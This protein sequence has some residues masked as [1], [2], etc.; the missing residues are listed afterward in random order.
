LHDLETELASSELENMKSLVSY[1][2][3]YFH[4]SDV[5]VVLPDSKLCP[6]NPCS[7]PRETYVDQRR[8]DSVLT[9]KKGR[10]NRN[11]KTRRTKTAMANL[12]SWLEITETLVERSPAVAG[13]SVSTPVAADRTNEYKSLKAQFLDAID[14]QDSKGLPTVVN[15]NQLVLQRLQDVRE[16]V[17]EE[18]IS[19][20][21]PTNAG[22]SRVERAIEDLGK[23]RNRGILNLLEGSGKM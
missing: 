10:P 2:L 11:D 8:I 7:L 5:F 6:Q 14:S 23:G 12:E 17:P 15:A 16:L 19:S 9:K 22:I 4:E 18:D 13:G 20:D 1:V 21:S 3:R